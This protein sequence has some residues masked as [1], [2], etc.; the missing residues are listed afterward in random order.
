MER[1][2]QEVR[3]FYEIDVAGGT[4]ADVL[5]SCDGTWQKRGF[6]SLYRVVFVIGYETGKVLDYHVMSKYCPG[7]R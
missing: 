3:E 1:A 5:I 2:R 6:T 4:T 7:C